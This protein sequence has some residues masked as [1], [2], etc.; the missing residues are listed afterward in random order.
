M[1]LDLKKVFDFINNDLLL[2]KL[3]HYG[4]RGLPLLW[5]NSYLTNRLQN[6]K[7]NGCFS[8]YLLISAG[9]P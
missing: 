8:N 9:V 5:L 4:V 6:F 1:L 7:T 2:V 3:K